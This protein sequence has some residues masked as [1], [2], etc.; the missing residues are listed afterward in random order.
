MRLSNNTGQILCIQTYILIVIDTIL[1]LL[2]LLLI[3]IKNL[4]T[5]VIML[6]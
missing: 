3:I 5:R 2:L 6:H 1:L 4:L